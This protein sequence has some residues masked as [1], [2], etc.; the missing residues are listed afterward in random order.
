M[1]WKISFEV[2]TEDPRTWD[3]YNAPPLSDEHMNLLPQILTSSCNDDV[4]NTPHLFRFS[5]RVYKV[6]R[7]Q[8]SAGD[9]M[10]L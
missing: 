3:P 1:S 7:T 4:A 5:L 9:D 2:E 8:M 6:F 10:T